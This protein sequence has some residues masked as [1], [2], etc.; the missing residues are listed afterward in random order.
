MSYLT[1]AVLIVGVLCVLDLVLTFG[2]IRRLRE[3]TELLSR[4]ADGPRGSLDIVISPGQVVGDFAAV[5][6]DGDPLSRAALTGQ[7]LVAFVSPDCKGC[8]ERL[9]GL[10]ERAQVM[11]GGRTQVLA[12]V[13]GEQDTNAELRAMLE[14]VARVVTD[15]HYDALAQAFKVRGFPAFALV[16]GGGV[17]VASGFDLA[18]LPVPVVA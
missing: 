10:V 5:T 1:A 17:V 7:T 6:T 3:H 14:P 9:P 4:R 16:A 11:P 15:G 2:I 8:T 12:V 18:E 13:A